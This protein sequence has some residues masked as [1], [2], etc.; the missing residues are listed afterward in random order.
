MKESKDADGGTVTSYTHDSLVHVGYGI[1]EGGRVP[2]T[3]IP[4]DF[5][6][7]PKNVRKCPVR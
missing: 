4:R 1:P 5:T 7:N 6:E 3:R 2:C